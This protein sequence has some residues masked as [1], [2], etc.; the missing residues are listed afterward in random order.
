[1]D[2]RKREAEWAEA[3]RRCCLNAETLRMAQELELNPRSLIKNI[4]S[5]SQPWKAP[6]A[7]WVR[8][9]HRRREEEAARRR[10]AREA[11]AAENKPPPRSAGAQ[12]DRTT[13]A[14]TEER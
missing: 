2:K 5:K 7:V 10:A 13:L 9:L 14:P 1:M 4:L 3:K 8:E 6:V 12:S 11:R